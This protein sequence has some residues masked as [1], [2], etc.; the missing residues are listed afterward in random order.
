MPEKMTETTRVP[1]TLREHFFDDP[2]FNSSWNEMGKF[3]DNFFQESNRMNKHF[4]ESFQSMKSN[5]CQMNETSALKPSE[6]SFLS[7]NWLR[8]HKWMMPK[9]FDDKMSSLFDSNDTNLIS[10]KDGEDKMEISLNTSGYKPQELKV[11][12]A[13]D[14][15]KVEGKHEEKSEDGHVMVSRQFSRTYGLP[16]GAKKAEVVSNLSQDGVMVITVP[17]EKKI[18]EIKEDQNIGIEKRKS[19]DTSKRT[20]EIRKPEGLVP[21]TMRDQFFEDPIFH[22]TRGD[23]ASSRQDF[24]KNARES[25]DK[26]VASMESDMKESRSVTERDQKTLFNKMD[27]DQKTLFNTLDTDKKTLFNTKDSNLIKLV[28]DDQKLEI[29]LDTSGYKP[30]ELR[31]TAGQGVITVEGKHEEKSQAGQVMVA[32]QFSRS[33]GLPAGAKPEEVVSNLSQDGV[34]VISV[35]KDK[36][37]LEEV[38]RSVPIAVK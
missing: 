16:T 23:I 13:E 33:Y 36:P 18:Q 6:N 29:S 30:D 28:D 9:V 25:F 4:D 21:L 19:S 3:R 37:A 2:F 15:V 20:E 14:A 7:H 10:M 38:K 8:P 32:R 12:V 22:S 1:M 11:Q 24:F 17:K 35:P 26:S 34:M 27:R 5:D 31:V